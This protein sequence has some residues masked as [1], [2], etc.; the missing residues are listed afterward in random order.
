MYKNNNASKIVGERA[1]HSYV[2]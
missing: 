2:W 1:H